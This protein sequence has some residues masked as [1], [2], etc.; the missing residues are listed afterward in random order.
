VL[1]A[2]LKPRAITAE[3]E[4][5]VVPRLHPWAPANAC[6]VVDSQVARDVEPMVG[7]AEQSR[8]LHAEAC[9]AVVVTG[10]TPAAVWDDRACGGD[11]RR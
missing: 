3:G 2:L 1:G 8:A 7:L 9:D 11:R 5:L 4:E 10:V 6:V